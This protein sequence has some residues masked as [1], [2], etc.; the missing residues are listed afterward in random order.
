MDNSHPKDFPHDSI[1]GAAGNFADVYSK[2]MESPWQFFAM[3]YL[4]C[5]GSLISHQITL[6]SEISPQPRLYTV[7]IGESADD[8]KSESIRQSTKFFDQTLNS[9]STSFSFNVCMGLGSAEGLANRAHG[10]RNLLLVYDELKAFVSKAQIDGSILTPCVNTLFESNTFHSSTK[11]K[12]ISLNDIYLS[13][14]G[15]CT[16]ETYKR[17]WTPAFLDIGFINRLFLV[18]GKGE[19]RFAIPRLIPESEKSQLESE[20]IQVLKFVDSLP[21]QNGRYA[22]P[23]DSDAY[24]LFESWY[25]AQE[26]SLFTKRLESYG[27]RFI[28]LLTINEH[29]NQVTADIVQKVI[30]LLSWQLEVRKLQDPIDAETLIAKIEGIIKRALIQGPLSKRELERKCN[31]SR[32]GQFYWDATKNGLIKGNQMG[33]DEKNGVYFL[34]AEP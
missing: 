16:A 29:Q 8:R 33:W 34:N 13:L 28:V 23:V 27:L 26:Q 7:V 20:L 1:Q 21:K 31:K 30:D 17:I 18:T 24:D 19:R 5:L 32:Y 6:Q 10:I 25:L 22:M 2:Y 11:K 14:L 12:S 9:Q 3:G 15:A 4:T